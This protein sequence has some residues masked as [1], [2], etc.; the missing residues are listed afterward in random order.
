[1]LEKQAMLALEIEEDLLL[2]LECQIQVAEVVHLLTEQVSLEALAAELLLVFQVALEQAGKVML[3]VM[4][5][6]LMAQ[7][8]QELEVAEKELPV[9]TLHQIAKAAQ[10]VQGRP[11]QETV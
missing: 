8:D 1:V 5:T 3:A 10:V 2:Y 6:A 11:G 7:V 9:K 4:E